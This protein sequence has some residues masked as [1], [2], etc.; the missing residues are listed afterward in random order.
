MGLGKTVMALVAAREYEAEWPELVIAPASVVRQWAADVQQW[1]GLDASEVFIARDCRK[2]PGPGHKFVVCSYGLASGSPPKPQAQRP[3][4]QPKKPPP[5][6]I[7]PCVRHDGGRYRVIIA[8]EA[9]ALKSWE[10]KR[11]QNLVPVLQSATRAILLTGTPMPNACAAEVHPLLSALSSSFK[12]ACPAQQWN[13]RFCYEKK[14]AIP[15]GNGRTF[16]KRTPAGILDPGALRRVLGAVQ[17]RKTVADVGDQLPEIHRT[18]TM[19]DCRDEEVRDVAMMYNQNREEFIEKMRAGEEAVST[20]DGMAP[21]RMLAEAKAPAVC[22]WLAECLFDGTGDEGKVVIFAHHKAMHDAI[23]ACLHKELSPEG[24]VHIRG[25]TPMQR[26]DDLVRKFRDMGTCR[27][28]LLAMQACGTGLNLQ[29][30]DRCV[31]A[32]LCW[33]ASTLEQAEARLRR[34]GQSARTVRAFYLLAGTM[35]FHDMGPEHVM[36]KA[37][38]AKQEL[39]AAVL[40]TEPAEAE[41]AS[42]PPRSP[43]ARASIA[44]GAT[45]ETPAQPANPGR[46]RALPG[47]PDRDARAAPESVDPGA[48]ASKRPRDGDRPEGLARRGLEERF[49]EAS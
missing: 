22:R 36:L 20:P 35:L 10:S 8:D 12:Q 31:F 46:A 27:A 47:A 37:V 19:V 49:G 26:R 18:F 21:F 23:A 25:D 3:G 6:W 24:F 4:A 9:H 33:S 34:T 11:T 44:G 28:A 13:D 45:M 48:S 16:E 29:V 39:T 42:P 17:L 30:A 5:P 15:M 41:K 43:E 32:E 38:R 40:G 14:F 1:L 7:S 2:R